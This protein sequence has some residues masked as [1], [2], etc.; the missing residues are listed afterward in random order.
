MRERVCQAD[1]QIECQVDGGPTG[2]APLSSPHTSRPALVWTT[3]KKP[4]QKLNVRP[5]KE[6]SEALTIKHE[7]CPT[8]SRPRRCFVRPKHPRPALPR[9]NLLSP[10]H[11]EMCRVRGTPCIVG[12][13]STSQAVCHVTSCFTRGKPTHAN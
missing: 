12:L 9:F 6:W 7:A 5:K 10:L 2:D 3:Q 13:F 1:N 8:A 11:G 4:L